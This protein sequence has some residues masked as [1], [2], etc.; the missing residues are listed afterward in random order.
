MGFWQD[1]RFA[2]RLLLKERWFTAVASTALALGIGV[3]TTVF[4]IANAVLFRGL[5]FDHPD[6][7]VALNSIDARGR[8]TG[9]SKLDFEDWRRESRTLSA[10]A[11]LQGVPM[12]ISEESRPAEQFPGVWA[13]ASLFDLIGQRPFIG[14]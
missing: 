14:R 12:N 11:L 7:L 10:G 2:A 5:P 4:T 6:R 8:Q 9:V 13:S 1:L 3:N